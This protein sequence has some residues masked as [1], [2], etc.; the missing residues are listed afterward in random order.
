M[1]YGTRAL[2]LLR[3]YYEFKFPSIDETAD[4]AN[5]EIE[6]VAE[7]E[8]GL[9]EEHIEPRKKLPPLLL[10]LSERMPEKL[11]YVGVS[12]GVTEPLLKF[13]QVLFFRRCYREFDEIIFRKRSEFVPVYL[14]QTTNELTGEHTCVMLNVIN[15]EESQ[16][17]DWLM[18]YWVDFRKRF[19]SLLGYQFRTF[20]PALS[21]GVLTNRSRK[22]SSRG[23]HRKLTQPSSTQFLFVNFINSAKLT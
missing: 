22:I 12:F 21:L 13:W 6:N 8:V 3:Q 2:N 18:A 10:K 23:K 16:K 14:R 20:S 1:G 11:D 5:E 17:E 15:S 4:E 7:D 9:L 19:I